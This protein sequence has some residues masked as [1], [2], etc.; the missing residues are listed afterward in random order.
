[1]DFKSKNFKKIKMLKSISYV[2]ISKLVIVLSQFF[3]IISFAKILPVEELGIYALALSVISPIVWA[4]TF[5]VPVKIISSSL[6]TKNLFIILFPH[7]LIL[8]LLSLGIFLMSVI[9]TEVPIFYFLLVLL[10]PLK[11]GEIISEIYNANLRREEKFIY[12]SLISSIRF[13][14]IYVFGAVIIISGYQVTTCVTVMSII[15]IIFALLSLYRLVKKGFYFKLNISDIIQY[16]NRNIKLGLASGIKFFSSNIMRYFIAFQFGISALGYTVPIFY[17]LTVLASISS[18]FEN[19]YSP[20]ISKK[21]SKRFFSFKLLKNELIILFL[22]SISIIISSLVLSDYYYNFFFLDNINN[23]H[24]LLI[25]FSFGWFFFT[26]RSILKVIS[27]KFKMQYLQVKIQF[28]FLFLLIIS[29]YT[30]SLYIG[31][32]GVAIAF[33]MSNIAICYYYIF[34]I[35]KY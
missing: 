25:A 17:G 22:T 3:F 2:A 26:L 27:F 19:V 6:E 8:S 14:M 34:Q 24:Y 33:V 30:L 35:M 12:F 16:V 20:K 28:I 7:I 5:D 18:I 31:I 1:M 15:S 13:F 9:L 29:M 4:L 32:L 21:I 23:Y 10:L 11:I